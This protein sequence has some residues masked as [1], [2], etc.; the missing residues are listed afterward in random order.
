VVAAWGNLIKEKDYLIHCLDKIVKELSG[1][2][3][4]WRQIGNLTENKNPRHPR[5]LQY[6]DE[7][8]KSKNL[9]DLRKFEYNSIEDYINKIKRY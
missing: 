5:S 4:D 3:I 8:E 7:K 9:I 6:M 1:I 2:E